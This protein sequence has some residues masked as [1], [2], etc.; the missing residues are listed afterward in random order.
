MID[1][2]Q[3]QQHADFGSGTDDGSTDRPPVDMTPDVSDHFRMRPAIPVNDDR[4]SY[5]LD[6]ATFGSD[7][8]QPYTSPCRVRML[9]FLVEYRQKNVPLVLRDINSVGEY[10]LCHV[11]KTYHFS[12]SCNS[13]IACANMHEIWHVKS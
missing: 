8:F 5:L 10:A 9:N 7:D 11:L 2:A 12:A 13:N 3:P 6:A 4:E 1:V